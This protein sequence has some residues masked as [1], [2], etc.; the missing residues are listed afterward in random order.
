MHGITPSSL[1]SRGVQAP[2]RATE[3]RPFALFEL[4]NKIDAV[5]TAQL[6]IREY[7]VGDT[8]EL[9]SVHP[10]LKIPNEVWIV[11]DAGQ[12]V[13]SWSIADE[14]SARCSGDSDEGASVV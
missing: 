10:S 9:R 4:G 5:R 3:G 11:D 7:F 14:Y 1:T 6:I 8:T 13:A 12:V 2:D